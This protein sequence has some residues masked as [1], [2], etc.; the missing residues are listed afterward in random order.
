[1]DNRRKLLYKNVFEFFVT[2]NEKILKRIFK[3]FIVQH[4]KEKALKQK[5]LVKK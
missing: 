3:K 1:M 4:V 5:V 2:Q